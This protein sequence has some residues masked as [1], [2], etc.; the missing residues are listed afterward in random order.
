MF[1]VLIIALILSISL[2]TKDKTNR[3]MR[4]LLSDNFLEIWGIFCQQGIAGLIKRFS[5]SFS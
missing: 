4:N 2:K 1:G 5:I 3:K